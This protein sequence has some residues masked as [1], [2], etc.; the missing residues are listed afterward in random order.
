M[1]QKSEAVESP[2][3]M[4]KLMAG[5]ILGDYAL[6]G[7]WIYYVN[8]WYDNGFLKYNLYK[9]KLDGTQK[10]K[11][12]NHVTECPIKVEDEW[13][14]YFIYTV[15]TKSRN[16]YRVKKDGTEETI[17]SKMCTKNK[18]SHNKYIDNK[19]VYALKNGWIYFINEQ[20]DLIKMRVNG[21]NIISFGQEDCSAVGIENLIIDKD[22][23]YYRDFNIL[24]KMRIDGTKLTKLCEMSYVSEITVFDDWVF[25][26]TFESKKKWLKKSYKKDLW[27][28]HANGTDN[29]KILNDCSVTKINII[30]GWLY[31]KDPVDLRRMR[32]DG[33]DVQE[34]NH[35]MLQQ[36]IAGMKNPQQ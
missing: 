29:C 20:Y 33:T 2:E 8:E 25:Y 11:L 23:I 21:S 7:D 16:I 13:V 34:V 4:Q 28:I 31:Y 18:Q 22:W 9:V 3:H 24:Y 32:L 30:D 14:Y 36:E 17:L 5:V 6:D 35:K 26:T 19:E 12:N 27:K 15:E 10:T 1:P